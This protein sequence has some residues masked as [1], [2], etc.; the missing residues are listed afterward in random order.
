MGV[1]VISMRT[2]RVASFV[3]AAA[4][5][6]SGAEGHEQPIEIGEVST[7]VERDG[8]DFAEVMRRESAEVLSALDTSHIPRGKHVIVSL[9]LVRLDTLREPDT[10]ATCVVDATLRDAR[11]GSVFAILEGKA[12]VTNGEP[13]LVERTA[14]HGAIKGALTRIPEV[15]K[16]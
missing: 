6:A 14:L 3:L 7:Q 10:S 13:R 12:K 11:R 16:R 8:I 15:L 9:A 2:A 4:M 5:T 1:P